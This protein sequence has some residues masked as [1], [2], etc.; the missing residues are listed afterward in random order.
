MR[1]KGVR[2]G[3]MS[4]TCINLPR[5]IKAVILQGQRR[6]ERNGHRK[7][8]R[9]GNVEQRAGRHT[10]FTD[11][12]C[13]FVQSRVPGTSANARSSPSSLVS[14]GEEGTVNMDEGG[15]QEVRHAVAARGPSF[16]EFGIRPSRSEGCCVD[17]GHSSCFGL[18]LQQI[19]T[20]YHLSSPVELNPRP[21]RRRDRGSKPRNECVLE[22]W[23]R[24]ALLP[25]LGSD[26]SM[27]R[28][29]K[30]AAICIPA[31]DGAS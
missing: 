12:G 17:S 13:F 18:R 8:T 16:S 9:D 10:V 11:E 5:S 23:P 25:R 19:L 27:H 6:M 28:A 1:V 4:R 30:R 24:P 15:E 20:G 21:R 7:G 14:G 22:P 26:P 29:F 2:L 31:W 3:S